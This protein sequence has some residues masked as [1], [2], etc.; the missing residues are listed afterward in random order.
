DG[1]VEAV[2]PRPQLPEQACVRRRDGAPLAGDLGGDALAD[3]RLDPGVDQDVP[4]R[5]A[6]QVDEAG[7]DHAAPH[8]DA[9]RR[10]RL[11]QIADGG[12]AVPADPDVGPEPGR[13]RPID[14]A[15]AGEDQV[16]LG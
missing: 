9:A 15:T 6:E 4:L 13:A 10:A 7:G 3:L 14:H 12:D 1:D 2:E 16:V 5:L 11:C 8:V